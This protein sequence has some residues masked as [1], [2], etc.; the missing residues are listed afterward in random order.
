MSTF[1]RAG[2]IA[3]PPTDCW[4]TPWP[5]RNPDS[6]FSCLARWLP[7]S[8]AGADRGAK[9]RQTLR[10]QRVHPGHGSEGGFDTQIGQ[11]R[12]GGSYRAMANRQARRGDRRKNDRRQKAIVCPTYFSSA[13]P[14]SLS[15]R[16]PP[17]SEMALV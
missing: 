11:G 6:R 3:K 14:D 2:R 9:G 1:I 17:S 12:L 4:R 8:E 7:D 13:S 5:H 15:A 16:Q 10:T